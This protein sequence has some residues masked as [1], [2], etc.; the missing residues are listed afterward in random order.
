MIEKSKILIIAD[1]PDKLDGLEY[2]L[3]RADTEIHTLLGGEEVPDILSEQKFALLILDMKD[4]TMGNYEMAEQLRAHK[5]TRRLPL[6]IVTEGARDNDYIFKG[7]EYGAVVVLNKPVETKVILNR[8]EVFIKLDQLKKELKSQRGTPGDNKG[9]KK[10]KNET[11]EARWDSGKLRSLL[12]QSNDFIFVLEPESLE[13][14]YANQ[15][16]YRNLGYAQEEIL[17]VKITDIVPISTE[18]L[19]EDRKKLQSKQK[20]VVESKHKRKDG[21]IFPVEISL[22]LASFENEN[23]VMVFSRDITKH[24]KSEVLIRQSEQIMSELLESSPI[25]GVVVRKTDGIILYCSRRLEELFGYGDGELINTYAK[26]LYV[27]PNKHASLIEDFKRDGFVD[28]TEVHYKRRG[29]EPFWAYL[30]YKPTRYKNED[31]GIAWIYD[32]DA[33]KRAEKAITSSEQRFKEFTDVASD[34]FWELGKDSC[35]SFVSDRIQQALGFNIEYFTG[36]THQDISVDASDRQHW[37]EYHA[38]I[39]EKKPFKDFQ[40]RCGKADG[41]FVYLSVNGT[42]YFDEKRCFK[43]YRGTSRD[44]SLE[45]EAEIELYQAKETAENSKEIAEAAT[46]SKSEFLANMSHEIR[47]PMNAIIGFIYLALDT[48]LSDPQRDYLDKIQTAS[49]NLLGIIDDILDFSKIE[50]GK[51]DV[52]NIV[53]QIEDV[54]SDLNDLI[55]LKARDKGL[56]IIIIHPK[57]KIVNLIGD[58]LRLRQVLINLVGNAVKFTDHGQVIISVEPIEE[59]KNSITLRFSIKDTGI[60]MSKTECNLLFNSFS[61]ADTSTT[62]RFGGS[63]LGLAISKKLV[64]LMGGEMGVKSKPNHGSTFFFTLPLGKKLQ[65]EVETKKLPQ[66]QL[67]DKKVLDGFQNAQIL[68]AEDNEINQQV[69]RKILEKNGVHVTIANNG[70]QAV[71]MVEQGGFDLVLMDIQMPEMDGYQATNEIRQKSTHQ[72]IPIVAMTAHALLKDRQKCLDAGMNDHISKPINPELLID[73]L[74]RWIK[75]GQR[76]PKQIPT[77]RDQSDIELPDRLPGLN[78][79]ELKKQLL[80]DFGLLRDLL[81]NFQNKKS[82]SVEMIEIAL[83]NVNHKQAIHIAHTI[84]GSAGALG[85]FELSQ[86]AKRLE[87]LLTDGQEYKVALQEFKKEFDVVFNSLTLLLPTP[88]NNNSAKTGN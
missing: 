59:S 64:E 71:R 40:Y 46:E 4:S 39:K 72:S 88:D 85:A 67:R 9:H 28:N 54:L 35:F 7:Y 69:A 18:D 80:N 61:Q 43:G 15:K 12:D 32:I 47:T 75:P 36:K 2:R 23:Y 62:R 30:K 66:Q 5:E 70:R 31:A 34:W 3:G 86:K 6:L 16:A 60:G 55:Q 81:I 77:R 10:V 79:K 45:K 41:S 24:K 29:K 48:K 68:L 73:V 74:I 14:L 65:S 19:K 8:T 52:E 11:R 78:L 51:M 1:N 21:S 56:D 58:P 42:P 82:D 44:I 63:G 27:D 49:H 84:N 26:D 76:I 20:L 57:K 38:I 50:A 22:K 13:I 37:S 25:G 33:L 87:I 53:F 17:N 83:K